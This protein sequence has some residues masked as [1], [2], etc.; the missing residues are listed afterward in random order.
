[1]ALAAAYAVVLQAILLA[2]SVP[3]A[4][5]AGFDAAPICASHGTSSGGPSVPDGHEQ[6]RD[7]H[8]GQDCLDACLTGCCCGASLR[9]V[10]GAWLAAAPALSQTAAATVESAPVL[11]QP[12]AF[13][14]RSRAPPLA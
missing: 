8:Q 12:V 14:H 2:F 1:V 6:N 11:R 5:A 7:R 9:A 3:I 4:G 13:A 10:P